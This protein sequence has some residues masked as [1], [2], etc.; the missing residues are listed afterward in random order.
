MSVFTHQ[1]KLWY[2]CCNCLLNQ[3]NTRT[4]LTVDVNA[5]AI[6]L[7]PSIYFCLE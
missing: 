1:V 5:N 7:V 4:I 6:A 3:D 2:L